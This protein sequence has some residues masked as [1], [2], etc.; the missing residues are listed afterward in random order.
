ML[1]V[2]TVALVACLPAF[3]FCQ[4]LFIAADDFPMNIHND[5]TSVSDDQKVLRGSLSAGEPGRLTFKDCGLP[6]S[7][8]TFT[9]VKTIPDPPKWGQDMKVATSASLVG[10]PVT[11]FQIHFQG[12]LKILGKERN[13]LNMT[14]D[15]CTFFG[16]QLKCPLVG[17]VTTVL[18]HGRLVAVP[19]GSFH[20]SEHWY[21]DGKL[22]GC[23]DSYM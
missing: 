4:D 20:H 10:P 13:L 18:D 16:E 6:G 8:L 12:W 15:G 5:A 17:N 1:V 11:N 21:S 3:G 14:K 2:R 7:R 19:H 23:F 22:L 9:E